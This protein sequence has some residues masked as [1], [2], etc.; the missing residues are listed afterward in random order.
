MDYILITQVNKFVETLYIHDVTKIIKNL[1]HLGGQFFPI[2][3]GL[4]SISALQHRDCPH[5]TPCVLE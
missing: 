4:G 3:I 2:S 1:G 5:F